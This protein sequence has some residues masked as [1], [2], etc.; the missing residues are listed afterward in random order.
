[1]DRSAIVGRA[2]P[3]ARGQPAGR[4][5][6]ASVGWQGAAPT[7][8][9]GT[10]LLRPPVPSDAAQLQALCQDPEIGRWTSVPTPYQRADA[11]QWVLL[12]APRGWAASTELSWPVADPADPSVALGSV[13]LHHLDLTDRV[14][15]VG[16]WVAA[17]ARGRGL[18][19][20]AVGLACRWAFDGLGLERVDWEAAV[21]NE[22]SRRV[23]L[24]VGFTLEGTARGRLVAHGRRDDSWLAG[25]LAEDPT[26]VG[27]AVR[28]AAADGVAS[29]D[30]GIG[31]PGWPGRFRRPWP[32]DNDV[33]IT[34]GTLHLRP[35]RRSDAAA[36]EDLMDEPAIA[37]WNLFPRAGSARED[38]VRYLDSVTTERADG[39]ISFAVVDATGGQLLGGIALHHLDPDART[40]EAGY[41]TVPAAR[42]RGVARRALAATARWGFGALGLERLELW[43]AVGNVGSCRVAA[44]AG[45]AHEAT[46]RASYRYGD[47]R[48]HDEHL[49][50]RLAADP[51]PGARPAGA[52]ATA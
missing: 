29:P 25:L 4:P 26:S 19:T 47:G 1:M 24:R 52:A 32:V 48:R 16:Y 10:V 23:A 37:L 44:S 28:T 34:A 21:G 14:G 46:T 35:F 13:A 36:L 38:A 15:E 17:G 8:T 5:G 50:G 42:G 45:F 20:R 39:A 2:Q 18:A 11:D 51:E 27:G 7:L 30:D 49:H 12:D 31:E 9:D 33:E 22:A 41:W 6:P 40:G 3:G 43:H